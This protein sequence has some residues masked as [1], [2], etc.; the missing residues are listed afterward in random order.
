M[1]NEL[2][3]LK[4]HFFCVALLLIFVTIYSLLITYYSL[5]K[6][7]NVSYGKFRGV[8]PLPLSF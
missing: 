6:K 1:I 3:K 4:T 8:V 5:L 7:V 2:Q